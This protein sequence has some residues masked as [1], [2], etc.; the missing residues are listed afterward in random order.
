MGKIPSTGIPW[1]K[2]KEIEVM[3]AKTAFGVWS[4]YEV[5]VTFDGVSYILKMNEGVRGLNVP[6]TVEMC[7]NHTYDAFKVYHMGREL[8]V[9]R[10]E[11]RE[12]W[13]EIETEYGMWSG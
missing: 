9:L 10:V 11:K 12:V 4:G 7:G 2:K 13:P 8:I 6:V 3:L 1:P 5:N